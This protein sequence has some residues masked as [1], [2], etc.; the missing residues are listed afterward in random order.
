MKMYGGV[1]VYLNTKVTSVQWS[2][3]SAS[4]SDHFIPG[5]KNPMV[6]IRKSSVDP[7]ACLEAAEERKISS[8]YQKLNPDS[9]VVKTGD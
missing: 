9:S 3:W 7:T 1:E 6:P 8:L 5:G 2:E 4:R